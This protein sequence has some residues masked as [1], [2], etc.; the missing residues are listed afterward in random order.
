MGVLAL[1]N[2]IS[3]EQRLANWSLRE[4]VFCKVSPLGISFFFCSFF[5][6]ILCDVLQC[7]LC[8][9]QLKYAGNQTEYK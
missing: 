7:S 1:W 8:K 6:R 5:N 4:T 3:T 9:I 2:C